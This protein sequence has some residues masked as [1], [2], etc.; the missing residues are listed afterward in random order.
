MSE[1]PTRVPWEERDCGRVRE[2]VART[3]KTVAITTPAERV[4]SKGGNS[5]QMRQ[6]KQRAERKDE[7][8]ET[9]AKRWWSTL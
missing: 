8:E 7:R 1:Y 3:N 2:G 5:H 6:A 4:W 9:Q